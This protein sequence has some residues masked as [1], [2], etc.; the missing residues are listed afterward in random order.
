M[1]GR[2]AEVRLEAE[3]LRLEA[4]RPFRRA[5]LHRMPDASV[6][7]A[8]E[9][10]EDRSLRVEVQIERASS[11]ARDLRQLHDRRVV[12]AELAEDLLRRVEQA[13]ARVQSALRERPPV[14][15]RQDDICHASTLNSDF[16]IFPIELRGRSST[17]WKAFG[18]L[19]RARCCRRW[20]RSSSSETAEKRTTNATHTSP[21]RSSGA[22][23]TAASATAGCS[24]STA[25]ISAGEM[26]SPPDTTISL[27][28]PRMR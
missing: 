13:T 6:Q 19:K 14:D 15:I 10:V 8:Y 16:V 5:L 1:L 21:Q 11:D 20:P 25:S 2:G 27:A 9:L 17:T 28:R 24:C 26:F 18:T 22:P 12:V 23:T 3:Q 7:V 4:V